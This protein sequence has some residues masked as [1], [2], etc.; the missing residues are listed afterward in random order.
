MKLNAMQARFVEEYLVSLNATQAAINAGY[1]ERTANQQA[2]RLLANVK[3]RAILEE[4]MNKRSEQVKVDAE[5]VLSRLG[6]ID[7]MD[8][9]DILNDDGSVKA[10]HDWPKIWRQ[11]ISGLDVMEIAQGD[12]ETRIAVV[13]KIKWPDKVKNLELIGRHVGVQ[14]F[15]DRVEH[16]G[17]IKGMAD[18]MRRRRK[19]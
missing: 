4:A 5:Y 19:N 11:M 13:K 8:A 7:Q 6:E 3:V 15:K 17:S 18:R 2:S 14:A 1:S 12:E 10:I 16:S 9:A